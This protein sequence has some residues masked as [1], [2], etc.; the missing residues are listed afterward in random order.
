MSKRLQ[1]VMDD[2]EWKEIAAVARRRGQTVSEW[3]R[4]ALRVAR[5]AEATVP[6][7]KKLAVIRAAARLDGPTA[8]IGEMLREIEA[9]YRGPDE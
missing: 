1:V 4:A 5:R 3:V 6:S 7:E 9:G 8:D 2:R